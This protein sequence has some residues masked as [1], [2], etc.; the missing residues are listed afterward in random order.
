MK[1]KTRCI[2]VGCALAAL[3]VVAGPNWTGAVSTN[4]WDVG[5]WVGWPNDQTPESV[6]SAMAEASFAD[7]AIAPH[8]NRTADLGGQTVALSGPIWVLTGAEI[9]VRIANGTVSCSSLNI[10]NASTLASLTLADV[11]LTVNGSVNVASHY[12]RGGKGSLTVESGRLWAT[13]LRLVQTNIEESVVRI[14]GGEVRFHW[15]CCSRRGGGDGL[16]ELNG[17]ILKVPGFAYINWEGGPLAEVDGSTNINMRLVMNGGTLKA[18]TNNVGNVN[19][20]DF[21]PRWMRVTL[22]EGGAVIDT[23]GYDLPFQATNLTV[24]ANDG[25]FTKKGAGTLRV[26]QGVFWHGPT[27]VLGGT[28][29]L[30]GGTVTG[31]LVLG[32]DGRIV[33]GTIATEDIT[34]QEGYVFK[35]GDWTSVDEQ[36]VCRIE[37][38]SVQ[39]AATVTSPLNG[40][41]ASAS[42]WYD[43]SDAATLVKNANN[44]VVEIVNKGA[45][46]DKM[47]GT[48]FYEKR[49]FEERGR[50]QVEPPAMAEINGLTALAFTNNITGFRTEGKVNFS[51]AFGKSVFAVGKRVQAFY[52]TYHGGSGNAEV[53]PIEWTGGSYIWHGD[54][55]FGLSLQV[56]N[57]LQVDKTWNYYHHA[58]GDNKE[59]WWNLSGARSVD[60]VPYVASQRGKAQPDGEMPNIFARV[61]CVVAGERMDVS[62]SRA[63]ALENANNGNARVTYGW[64]MGLGRTSNGIIGEALAFARCLNEAE[65]RIVQSYLGRKWISPEIPEESATLAFGSL[66]LS[67]DAALDLER[68]DATIGTLTGAG[69]LVNAG[70]VSVTGTIEPQLQESSSALTVS[71]PV[72]VTGSTIVLDEADLAGWASNASRTVLTAASLVGVPAVSVPDGGKGKYVVSNT[73]TALVV[74]RIPNGMAIFVR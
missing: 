41:L 64:S 28:L 19:T 2:L 49:Y 4:W 51:G 61:T 17:G 33:N 34:I 11:D 73:G 63:E 50:T 45:G 69:A 9:P 23:N 66:A 57:E 67:N 39:G 68:S 14:N 5:N 38:L 3:P 31:P 13:D 55:L 1:A 18:W 53:Y 8:P 26:E 35:T 71:G 12:E 52:D 25:G 6:P 37:R 40:L 24:V 32:G 48:L 36:G 54:N 65:A 56:D 42:V 15:F 62:G 21:V 58:E 16:L 46:G 7:W 27:K 44:G 30:C 22:G 43:P 60:D 20:G 29:D 70:N 74:T 72:D 59:T 47:N 10:R